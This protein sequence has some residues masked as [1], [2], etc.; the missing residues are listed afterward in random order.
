VLPEIAEAT[1]DPKGIYVE[2]LYAQ[3]C[4]WEN[5]EGFTRL[6]HEPGI[7]G[8][9]GTTGTRLS[10]LSESVLIGYLVKYRRLLRVKLSW[11]QPSYAK[12]R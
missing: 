9:A 2:N 1:D 12:K 11:I 3:L 7:L 6:E 4:I 8:Q 10:V 5:R